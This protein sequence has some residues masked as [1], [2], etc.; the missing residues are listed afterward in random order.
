MPPPRTRPVFIT[1]LAIVF[2][3]I[4]FGGTLI[5]PI[6]LL[7]GGMETMWKQ[8]V[9]GAIHSELLVRAV[10]W[11]TITVWF[12][13]YVAYAIIGVGLWKLRNWARTAQLVIFE[14]S[15]AVGI[16]IAA[17][18]VRPP[19]LA[20]AVIAGAVPPFAWFIWYL[21]R[22]RV[23]FAFGAW[24]S[25]AE[26]DS[27]AEPPP[28]LSKSGKALVAA[29]IVVTFALY[30]GALSFGIEDMT[31]STG[32]YKIAMNYARNSPCVA[33]VL[34]TPATPDRG[35]E[36]SWEENSRTGKAD[37]EIPLHGPKDKGSLVVHAK[38]LDGVWNINSL[39][40]LHGSERIKIEPASPTGGCQ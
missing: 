7:A 26:A 24:P 34:G 11:L 23:R 16:L 36:G 12:L 14:F 25:K 13:F 9:G 19:S 31:R 33:S 22:P 20:F 27:A 32:I 21:M 28:G 15:I 8:L 30:I 3:W 29:G 37:I 10:Y 39:V 38:K 40:L 6:V 5:F 18:L 1:I 35:T 4:G 17:F 2:I